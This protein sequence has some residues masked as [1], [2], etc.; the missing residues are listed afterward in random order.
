MPNVKNNASAQ[1]TCRKLLEAAGEVFAERG[2]HAATIKEI[3]TRAGVNGAAINYH[4]SDKFELYAAVIRYAVGNKPCVTQ[5]S[6]EDATPEERLRDHI[7]MQIDD[8]YSRNRPTWHATLI[9]HELAQP[10]DALKAVMDELIR[11]RITLSTAIIADILGPGATEKEITYSSMS[12]GGQCFLYTYH[13][14]LIKYAYPKLA[15]CHNRDEIIDHITF[16]SLSA[17]QA[18][19]EKIRARERAEASQ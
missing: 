12:I 18:M 7:A 16:F 3:T 5:L 4:F 11:P 6:P 1:E 17:L 15:K 8:M 10:T 14:E 2:L 9:A 13:Q 19:R